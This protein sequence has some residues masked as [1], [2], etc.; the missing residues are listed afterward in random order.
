MANFPR[1]E[2]EAAVEKYCE[3]RVQVDEGLEEW[4]NIAQFFT[5]DAVFID[6]A[7]GR[8]EGIDEM[9]V[10]FEE[11]MLGL[12]DWTFPV[13]FVAIEGDH[14]VIKWLQ[15]LPGTREDGTPYMQSGVSTLIYGGGG[16]FRY[17]EDL[18]NMVHVLE[19]LR[20][21]KWRPGEG[22]T[23]P[24]PNPNRDFSKPPA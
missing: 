16:K 5:D 4:K 8:V 23:N 11:S 15:V 2:I 6:P 24:P 7:W 12:E 1:A 14:V 9:R 13:E 22:F 3:F 20:E 10:F 21:S 19:D 17:E 18:L